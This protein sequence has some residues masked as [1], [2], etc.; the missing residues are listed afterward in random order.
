M[1]TGLLSLLRPWSTSRRLG[2][3]FYNKKAGINI[4]QYLKILQMLLAHCSS[5]ANKKTGV[6]FF[7][8][9]IVRDSGVFPLQTLGSDIPEMIAQNLGPSIPSSS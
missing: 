8:A 3:T 4:F 1:T 9:N 6:I 5:F 2:L 7:P